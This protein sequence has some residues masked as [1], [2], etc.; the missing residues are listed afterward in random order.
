[1]NTEQKA[2]FSGCLIIG[3]IFLVFMAIFIILGK[4]IV[5]RIES[6]GGLRQIVIETGKDVK[7]IIDEINED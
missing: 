7:Q 5:S 3:V 2:V 6:Q 4:G 1:M